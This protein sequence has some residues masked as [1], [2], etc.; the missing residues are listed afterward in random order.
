MAEV[1]NWI[2][3]FS[4]WVN[5][6]GEFLVMQ[7]GFLL[8]GSTRHFKEHLAEQDKRHIKIKYQTKVLSIFLTFLPR[9][10]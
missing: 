8:I 1:W 10:Y 7:N 5:G 9:S 6:F 4:L 2:Y 3:S